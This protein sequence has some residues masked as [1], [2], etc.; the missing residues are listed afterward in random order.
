MATSRMPGGPDLIAVGA[1]VRAFACSAARTGWRMH[2]ADLFGDDDLR[3]AVVTTVAAGEYGGL[4]YPRSLVAAVAGLPTGPWCYTGAIE[5][6][7]D[8]IAAIAARRPLLGTAPDAVRALRDHA[9]LADVVRGS[10]LGF[11]DTFPTPAHVPCDG[12]FLVKPRASAG[13]RGITAWDRAAD[14]RDADA[15][16]WQRRVAGEPW[17]A[18]FVVDPQGGVRLWGV[19]RQLVGLDWC[20]ARPFAYCGSLDLP[21]PLVPP[22]IRETLDRL[23]H[24]LADACAPL[25]LAGLVGVDL[26]VDGSGHMSV[27]EVNPRPTASMELVERATGESL[28]AVHVAACGGQVPTHPRSCPRTTIWGKCVLFAACDIVIDAT[29]AAS[30]QRACPPLTADEAAWP[31]LADI[32]F[33]GTAISAR[34]PLLT[35]FAAADTHATVLERLRRRAAALDAVLSA[36]E[37][38]RH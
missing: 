24:A 19:S 30:L 16:V 22:P 5:N 37:P 13:G 18:A 38:P 31:V 4:P 7:P 3:A 29:R 25:G 21:L 27:L 36:G 28:A 33:R 14:D 32:P 1:S 10:G 34:A 9:W 2:A 15:H 20:H 6:H 23:G 12:T 35:V 26:I 11:P 8:V 17:A